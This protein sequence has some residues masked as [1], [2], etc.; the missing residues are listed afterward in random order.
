MKIYLDNCASTRVL[1]EAAKTVWL[2][3]T[4]TYANPSALHTAGQE[5]ERAVKQAR[6]QIA[7][8]LGTK[9][10]N[11]VFTSGG[12]ESD[13]LALFSAFY[14]GSHTDSPETG[15]APVKEGALLVSAVEHPAVLSAA[16]VLAARGVR[17]GTIPVFK[18]GTDF[19]GMVDISAFRSL[20]KDDVA[21]VSVMHVN[22]EIGTIQPI[23]E[24]SRVISL[25]NSEH[26]GAQ[27]RF[28]V[29][30]VQSYGKLAIDVVNGDFRRVDLV[31]MSA[32]KLHGPKGVGALY[33]AAPAKLH[34][35]VY[36]GG[37][38]ND[39]RSG[40]ENVPGIAG[41][42]V[43]ARVAS[44]DIV[45]H[46]KQANACRRRLL[47]RITAEISDVRVN[48]PADA[49]V[50]GKPGCSSPYILNISF[51]GTRAEVLVHEL[52]RSGIFVS[53][54][55]ACASLGKNG[56]KSSGTL[57]A[58]GVDKEA[59]E[60]AIRFGISWINTPEEMD[61]VVDRLAAAVTRF[62]RTGSY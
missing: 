28:H 35:M 42:G 4:E 40:T 58:L 18:A 6:H 32:H 3:M 50:T 37:Q 44:S 60:G 13:N 33:A 9:P 21:L 23:D 45:G 16:A 43:S 54:G 38:E 48:S 17:V 11:I 53:T 10:G 22:N 61:F 34:P 19:P 55:A 56:E 15:Q 29:D 5:A 27:V 25:Y 31:S 30:A 57:T 12:T 36:G 8:T 47:E 7:F 24:I 62:R 41:F 1:P 26:S 46:A 52:E 49:S 59:A 51:L 20:L 39:V 14:S 2:A